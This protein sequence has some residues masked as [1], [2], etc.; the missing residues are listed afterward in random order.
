MAISEKKQALR[1]RL[2]SIWDH[3]DFVKGVSGGLMDDVQV[4]EMMAFIDA[5]EEEQPEGRDKESDI[6]A[7]TVFIRHG[8]G[9]LLYADEDADEA[10]SISLAARWASE[11]TPIRILSE[12]EGE[13]VPYEDLPYDDE[14]DEELII[15]RG[16]EEAIDAAFAEWLARNGQ[17]EKEEHDG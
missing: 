4:D 6:V 12:G 14:E 11:K 8:E 10:P 3:D 16:H 15:D 1:E 2:R 9:H 7:A 13:F 5:W 17:S